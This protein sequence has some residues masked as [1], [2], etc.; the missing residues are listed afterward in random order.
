[1]LG[2]I[3]AGGTKFV[4]AVG[5]SPYEIAARHVIPTRDPATT[6]AD[7]ADWFERQGRLSALGI[8]SFGPVVLDRASPRWGQITTTPK[9][10][11]SGCSL[12]GFFERRLQVPVGFETDV[13]AAALAEFGARESGE[14]NSLAYVTVG[15]GIGGGLVI[16]GVPVHG[17][18]HPEMGHMIPRRHPGDRVFDGVCPHHGDCLEGLASGPAITARWGMSLSELPSNHAAH[19]IVAFYLAQ[20]CHT[21]F[22]M[23]AVPIIVLGGGVMQ[24]D[25]LLGR[26]RQHASLLDRGYLPGSHCQRI[27]TPKLGEDSGITGALILARNA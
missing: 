5:A 12:A 3:E 1:M 2:G 13:N 11:W 25:G 8:A 24:T 7:A 15:T 18:A 27:E 16:G 19:E 26:V 20:L 14:N 21:L 22:A 10:G 23:T 6:L 4:L 9:P 17:V